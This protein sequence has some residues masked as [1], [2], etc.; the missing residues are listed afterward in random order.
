[1]VQEDE[2]C[3][4]PPVTCATLFG[5]FRL[6][7]HDGREI[8]FSNRRA[9]A[10]M[11]M[12]CVAGGEALDRELL[13]KLLWPGRFE[14]HAKASLR[15]CLLDLGKMLALNGMEFLD[16][17]RS[18]VAFHPGAL[19]SDLDAIEEA[20]SRG[21]FAAGANQ[22]EAIGAK[23]ILGQIDLGDAFKQWLGQRSDQIEQRLQA[24][25]ARALDQA[26][27]SAEHARLA[28]A[29]SR[30]GPSRHPVI[31]GPGDK[32]PIAVLPFQTIGGHDSQD[33]FA[34]G[35]VDEL[36]TALGQVK[37]LRVAGRTSSFHF[38]NSDLAPAQIAADLGVS[39][40][41]EG[42]V[43]RQEERVRI[44]VRL[45]DGANGF[46]SWGQR[47]DGSLDSIFVLQETVAQAVTAAIG[48]TLG[49]AM[50]P[51]SIQGLTQ[52]KA[53][54]D[55]Y[56]QGRALCAR[57]FGDGVLEKAIVLLE[58][59]LEIDPQ[60]AECW[61]T[62][63]EAHQLIA[64]YTQC[65]DRVAAAQR[66]A[67]CANRAIELSPGMAYPWS[68]LG[69]HEFAQKNVVGALDLA[70]KAY[71]MEPNNPAVT[72]RVGTFLIYCGRIANA[73]PY[74]RAAIDQDPV[75]PRK[76]AGLWTVHMAR[77]ELEQA[78]AAAQ[79][80]VDLG[81]PSMYLGCTLAAMGQHER[82]IEQYLRTQRLVNTII[83][84]P[85]GTGEMSQEA[86]DAYWLVAAKGICSGQPGDRLMYQQLLEMMYATLPDK[87]DLA[88]TGP[89]AFTGSAE[90]LFKSVGD[91]LS[92]ANML[93][94]VTIWADIDPIRQIWQHPEFIP[95]AQR[96]GMTA[97][98][99]KY[100]W[101]DLLP[102]PTNRR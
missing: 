15:Q 28:A 41:I 36:I 77:R 76:Y 59:A 93:T 23:P 40:L 96:I 78:C 52:S 45:I 31:S 71:R 55:L 8:I 24:A 92:P 29:L 75:D 60:F 12:L 7:N 46:E 17:T 21:D 56:L 62:L 18:A 22:L 19:R 84:P 48:A 39:H 58:Q 34:D 73:E 98:W 66:M 9:R 4:K 1:M 64:V 25:V 26:G 86:M 16:I 89:A 68:L 42:S 81:F 83:M 63:A 50:Q 82:A 79:K 3:R 90:L 87:G 95:F 2:R 80:M 101:P 33:Y 44:H 70:F 38:R 94:L 61:V 32:T 43:Q 69:L 11:A 67:D 27:G 6:F 100:G 53:A 74:V 51:P 57:V 91:H 20:L 10:L 72:L 35:M 97:A 13:A 99:D 88:I 85:V 54:Y 5:P 102:V 65:P 30:R 14:A 37:Q 47:F 49:V